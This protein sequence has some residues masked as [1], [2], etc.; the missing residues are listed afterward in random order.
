MTHRATSRRRSSLLTVL[1][2][3][4]SSLFVTGAGHPPLQPT[5]YGQVGGPGHAGLYGWGAA[6]MTDGTVLI[7]D[8][9][10]RRVQR[11]NPDGTLVGTLIENPGYGPDQH[12]APY[13]LG[14]DPN[15]GDVYMADTDRRG[16]DKYD[17]DGNFILSFGT[18]GGGVGKF[19]Y[20]S[21]VAVA[22]DGMVFVADTWSNNIVAHDSLGNELYAWGSFGTALGNMKQ[23]HGIAF[24][25][26]DRLF[27]VDTNNHRVQVF[28]KDGTP[29][30][31]FGSQGPDEGQFLGDMRGIAI[32]D[33]RDAVYV[34]DGRG[35]R[36]NRFTKAG[37]FVNRWGSEGFGPGQFSDGAREAT[38]DHNGNVWVADMP[39]FRA[40]VF[41]PDGDF[42]FEVPGPPEPPPPGGFN[43]PR[44]VALDAAGNLFVS[45][46]Y[47]WRIE[48]FDA[49]GDFV[50][51]WG[52]R[53]R[54][55]YRFN[56]A[57]LLAVDP[58]DQTVVIA[59]TDNHQLKRYTNDGVFVEDISFKG[60]GPGQVKA[61]HGVDIGPDGK[62][63]VA[64]TGNNRVVVLN[65]DGSPN[66][67][68]GSNGTG[69]GN[70]R[71]PK[72]IAVDVD[73]TI[74]VTDSQNDD[75]QH[76]DAAGNYLGEVD[77]SFPGGLDG[78]FGV[79]V[80]DHHVFVADVRQAKV[81]MYAKDGT[82]VADV[83]GYGSD[84]GQLR[85][86]QGVA[87]KDGLLYVAERENDRIS[88][89]DL[90][91]NNA[92]TTP[93]DSATTS[94][95]QN[96]VVPGGGPITIS[97]TATDDREVASVKLAI[98]D[99]DSGSWL[100]GDGSFGAYEQLLAVTSDTSPASVTWSL[101]VNLP[102]GR[103]GF[104]V[105]TTD[106]SG[107]VDA[108]TPWHRF[109]VVSGPIDGADPDVTVTSPTHQGVSTT[110]PT[111]L[112]GDA[113]DDVGVA[114]VTVAIRDRDAGTWLQP[115]LVT[116]SPAYATIVTTLDAPGAPATGWSLDVSLP[117][118]R[119]GLAVKV[120]D[121]S[122]KQDPSTPWTTFDVALGPPDTVAPD[123]TVSSPTSGEAL[124]SGQT[125]VLSGDATDDVGVAVVQVALRDRVSGSWFQGDGTW[126]P[127]RWLDAAVVTPGGTAVTWSYDAGVLADGSYGFSLRTVDGAGNDDPSRPW[128]T[129]TV[130]P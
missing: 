13:G 14:V 2:L 71:Y 114:E 95:A 93:P 116:W 91:G 112:Q 37:V 23:P 103:Y 35:N 18:G 79:D 15:N 21:R 47:N 1:L 90:Y 123:G 128:T 40:Q 19:R 43:G 80:D 111:T 96:E 119:Y 83:G 106:T 104:H 117:E 129:F 62:I 105:K 52:T 69:P 60:S 34:T 8:Y 130:A 57:R 89:F 25:D 27:V 67:T 55:D 88:V 59:D 11:F 32:D 7:S 10:N 50:T 9:W 73:G 115:D 68:F 121:T 44:G 76:F 38:V 122:G 39:N 58:T 54:G 4:L 92:D 98:K 81:K 51:Q 49:D 63:Y 74:W 28:A 22:S 108:D 5:Y 120:A 33:S 124:P 64:D 56:Y 17:K 109:D 12:Q 61:P 107:N 20:P 46:M 16:V 31:A 101:E 65:P 102:D 84:P 53:G 78:P 127:H 36:V 70:F 30:Y 42:L 48:K 126:G 6:T 110:D 86:P 113:T 82:F 72:G 99:V 41:S 24:D 94:P 100:R 75:V 29:L 45:D 87:V 118:G 26:Q 85:A 66:M 77:L 125:V 3:A 97:G